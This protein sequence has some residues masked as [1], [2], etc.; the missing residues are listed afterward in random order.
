M[1]VSKIKDTETLARTSFK[2]VTYRLLHIVVIFFLS[3]V[4]TGSVELSSLFAG[5]VLVLGL[6]IYYIYD[7]L[8]L[9]IPWER[10]KGDD[11]KKRSLTKTIVY[12]VLTFSLAFLGTRAILNFSNA[13]ALAFF[14]T[15]QLIVMV[16][17]FIVERIYNAIQ[18]GKVIKEI[19]TT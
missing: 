14:V 6:A 9:L 17:Y 19:P 18:R 16:I 1:V 11:S 12:R 10:T 13:E 2:A 5:T 3:L 4:F 7:R 8:W 15:D